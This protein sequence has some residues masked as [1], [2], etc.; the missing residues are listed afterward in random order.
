M[1]TY[2][3]ETHLHTAESSACASA[4]GAQMVDYYKALGYDG[5]FVTDH[6]LP[7]NSRAKA[8]MPYEEQIE[9]FCSGYE[10]AKRR[11]DA[12]GLSVFFGV[13]YSYHGGNHFLL[14]GVD[15]TFLLSHPE[16]TTLNTAGV[17]KLVHEYGGIM[18]QAHPFRE[19]DYVIEHTLQPYACDG[20]EIVN[21][22]NTKE[23]NDMARLYAAH[24]RLQP[25][26]GSDIHHAPFHKDTLGA[27]A[28][29]ERLSSAED[30]IRCF[31]SGVLRPT[32]IR[33]D[34]SGTR[35]LGEAPL[36][37]TY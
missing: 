10:A 33:L 29:T 16:L 19:A 8:S 30:F 9:I 32:R 5:I 20:V 12:V 31:R 26:A 6:L 23:A 34:E 13:E 11:G 4:S 15:K 7:G 22:C 24:Y 28:S 27:I 2:L 3:Y 25:S 35:L 37:E 36:F 1:T 14:Y 17:A 18:V 21:A